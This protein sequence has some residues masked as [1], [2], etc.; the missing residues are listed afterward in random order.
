MDWQAPCVCIDTL[1]LCVCVCVC[2]RGGC[3][4]VNQHGLITLQR[5]ALFMRRRLAI[6]RLARVR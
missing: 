4:G 2:V 1:Y 5:F 3:C 6:V